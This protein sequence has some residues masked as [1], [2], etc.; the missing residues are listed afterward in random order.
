MTH[1]N[2]FK[3]ILLAASLGFILAACSNEEIPD[4]E[5]KKHHTVKMEFIGNVVGF[6][7]Q[8]STRATSSSWNDG[9]KIYLTFYSGSDTTLGEALYDSSDGWT[10][11][12]LG[13][14]ASGDT[15]KCEVRYFTNTTQV[16]TSFITF[17]TNSE[18]YED[19]NAQYLY[20]ENSLIVHASLKPKTGR[21]RFTG[22]PGDKIYITGISTY[23]AFN[24]SSNL[25]NS[26]N[27][28]ISSVVDSTGTTP[29]IYGTFADEKRK[30]GLL[31]QDFA[32]TRTCSEEMLRSGES[33][34]MSIPS[35]NS[36]NKWQRGLYVNASG[37][38]FMMIPVAGHESGFYLIGETEVTEELYNTIFD[39]LSTS[40]LPKSDITYYNVEN[41]IR[42]LNSITKLTF[43]LPTR[44]QWNYAAK[45]GK[46]SQG[47]TYSGS[48][49]PNEVAWY[50]ENSAKK[51]HIVKQKKPN[52]LGIYDMSGNVSEWTCEDYY[53]SFDGTCYYHCGGS[54]QDGTLYITSTG[55]TASSKSGPFSYIGFRLI[56]TC[57]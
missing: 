4:V 5:Q 32:F 14:L 48:N 12:L 38:G 42:N 18:I 45:G 49:L 31:G 27:E 29:Y 28:T 47:F 53:S 43:S 41:F 10:V 35:E 33:G 52:E 37:V 16:S 40:Q 25:Y 30:M 9:D 23:T 44:S 24:H 39:S 26:S 19:L 6:N 50:Y 56:L 21:I 11:S 17:N 57:P 2:Y 15:L 34:Y 36:H 22:M 51:K 7:Q 13:D 1:A 3:K 46:S 20:K 54:Y 8:S 55:N